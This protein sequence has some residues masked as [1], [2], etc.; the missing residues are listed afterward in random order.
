[1]SFLHKV[2]RVVEED[3]ELLS[4]FP[5]FVKGAEFKVLSISKVGESTGMTSV[6][7]KNGPYVHVKTATHPEIKGQDSWF[8]CFYCE[9]TMDQLKEIE[10]LASDFFPEAPKNQFDGMEITVRLEEAKSRVNGYEPILCKPPPIISSS[11]KNSSNFL[12]GLSKHK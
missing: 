12:T 2:F 4:Q 1:M 10:E 9:D 5:E 7:F 3:E 11:L 6:Q 8:W